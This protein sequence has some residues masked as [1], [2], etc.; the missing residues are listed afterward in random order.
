MSE[1]LDHAIYDAFVFGFPMY[2]LARIRH[3]D[4]AGTP[5]QAALAP[6]T[7]LHGRSLSGADDRW[8]TTPNNDTLYSRAW[9]DLS[10]GPVQI[11]V[12]QQ[13][14][15]RYWSVAFMDASTRN[16]AMLGQRLH[17]AGPVRVT[18]VGPGGDAAGVSGDI[19]RAPSND[20][21]LLARWIVAGEHDL[22]EARAMQE[23]LTLSFASP[24]TPD[25]VVPTTAM[26]PDNFLAVVA[27][28]LRRNPPSGADARWLERLGDVG[29]RPQL[30]SPWQHLG[31]EVQAAWRDGVAAAHERVKRAF[32]ERRR[33]VQGWWAVV[34]GLGDGDAGYE[35]RAGTA[36]GGLGGLDAQEA[37]YAVRTTDQFGEPLDGRR[38]YRLTVPASGIPAQAFWSISLYE[39]MPDGRKFFTHNP[40]NR[41]AIGDRTPGIRRG[42]DGAMHL[43]LQRHRPPT[44]DE[45][46]NWLPTPDGPFSLSL[47]AYHP[48]DA[49]RRWDIQMPTL[50][51][52]TG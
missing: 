24:A 3:R 40:I 9:L 16:F 46:A 41:Y 23:R 19:L 30:A 43:A 14:A 25:R 20:V 11:S 12:G 37:V 13:P 51:R 31:A 6:N 5:Q 48:S 35:W 32:I 8:V 42:A 27:E 17:G 4:L 52:L 36:L 22:P 29:L 45:A 26:D 15:G 21:W 49:L 38:D 34:D 1:Q 18:L 39:L 47:R 33:Q 7:L 2:E 50:E 28:Q 10:H 44:D